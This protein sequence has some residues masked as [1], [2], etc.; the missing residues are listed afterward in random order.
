[1]TTQQKIP[2]AAHLHHMA[3]RIAFIG[4]AALIA[5]LCGFNTATRAALLAEGGPVQSPTVLACLACIALMLR[6]WA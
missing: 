3:P 1:M 6:L 4:I 5:V 2:A